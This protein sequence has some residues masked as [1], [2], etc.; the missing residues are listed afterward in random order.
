MLKQAIL[1]LKRELGNLLVS[2]VIYHDPWL[3][4][5][6]EDEEVVVVVVEEE[7]EELEKKQPRQQEMN[8]V[9][10]SVD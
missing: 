6:S 5:E 10:S 9:V 8:V 3:S 4:Y 2:G 1:S 7:E